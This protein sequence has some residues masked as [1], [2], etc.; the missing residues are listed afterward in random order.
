[1]LQLSFHLNLPG[2]Y[3]ISQKSLAWD[4]V[5]HNNECHDECLI[6]QFLLCTILVPNKTGGLR[7]LIYSSRPSREL[8]FVFPR[9]WGQQIQWQLWPGTGF[10]IYEQNITPLDNWVQA[11]LSAWKALIDG[12]PILAVLNKKG[13]DFCYKGST[14][15]R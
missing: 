6:N 8:S 4:D 14:Q 12:L 11:I 7:I 1:M 2:L 10:K 3:I 13:T 15:S 9:Y 5:E